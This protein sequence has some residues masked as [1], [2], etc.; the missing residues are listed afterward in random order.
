MSDQP[1]TGED[2]MALVLSAMDA[3]ARQYGR[4]L[5]PTC[6]SAFEGNNIERFKEVFN[7]TAW[8]KAKPNLDKVSELSGMISAKLSILLEP[9]AEAVSFAI[10]EEATSFVR[11]FCP[12]LT[13]KP[14][15]FAETAKKGDW[16]TWPP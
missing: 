12:I 3:A 14:T 11:R 13:S 16:C 8:Q 2:A 15:A 5:E 9:Q 10:F 6:L 1:K 4:Q 7:D